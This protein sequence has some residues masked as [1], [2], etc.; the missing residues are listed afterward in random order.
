MQIT[1]EQVHA[2]AAAVGLAIPERDVANVAIR[3]SALLGA[4]EGIELELGDK[5]DRVDPV[6]PVFPREDF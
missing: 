2:M 4:M 6:P 1:R 5:M 3:L